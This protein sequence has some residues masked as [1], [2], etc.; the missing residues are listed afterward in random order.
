MTNAQGLWLLVL[1]SYLQ[2]TAESMVANAA[3]K[4]TILVW[5]AS[6]QLEVCIARA[7]AADG[8]QNG[9]GGGSEHF[10][11]RH[12]RRCRKGHGGL[13]RF[14]KSL[15]NPEQARSELGCSLYS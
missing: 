12:E 2:V 4:C 8:S 15:A 5:A 6:T 3:C 10:Q 11:M 13:C 7:G 9:E 1:T 14:V